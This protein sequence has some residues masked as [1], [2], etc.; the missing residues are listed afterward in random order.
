[1]TYGNYVGGYSPHLDSA[2]FVKTLRIG[3]VI[4]WLLSVAFSIRGN[5]LGPEQTLEKSWF[6]LMCIGA[7]ITLTSAFLAMLT[8]IDIPGLKRGGNG[9]NPEIYYTSLEIRSNGKFRLA[10]ESPITQTD[11]HWNSFQT[12][13]LGSWILLQCSRIIPCRKTIRIHSIPQRR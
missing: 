1:M 4:A 5:Y 9:F 6:W 10:S 3:V 11:Y 13:S 7:G 12:W 8:V 2:D